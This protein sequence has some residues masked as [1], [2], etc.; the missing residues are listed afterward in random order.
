M[1]KGVCL[2]LVSSDIEKAVERWIIF[3]YRRVKSMN[4]AKV[5]K[6]GD[7]WSV[8]VEFEIKTGIFS[9]QKH[10][11]SLQVDATTGEVIGYK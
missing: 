8:E 11:H 5:W 1:T 9:S 7:I 6:E 4:I 2:S 3:K 10:M